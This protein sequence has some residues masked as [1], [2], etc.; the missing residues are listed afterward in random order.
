MNDDNLKIESMNKSDLIAAYEQ[1]NSFIQYLENE[2][3]SKCDKE[4]TK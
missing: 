2:I 3:S 4:E 1:V